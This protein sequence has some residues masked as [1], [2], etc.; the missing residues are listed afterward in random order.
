MANKPGAAINPVREED[1]G[2]NRN[3]S[4]CSV[5]WEC[6]EDLDGSRFARMWRG[7][8]VAADPDQEVSI[9][10]VLERAKQG[11]VP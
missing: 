2:G 6:A 1:D 5:L 3:P 8:S 11:L 10:R 9:P 7:L 4:D